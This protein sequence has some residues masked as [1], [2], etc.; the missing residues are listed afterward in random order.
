MRYALGMMFLRAL[1]A[2]ILLA[3]LQLA[4]ASAAG[5]GSD[6]ASGGDSDSRRR[7]LTQSENYVPLPPLTASVQANYQLRGILHIEAGLDIPDARQRRAAERAMPRLRDAYVSAISI[8][9]GV[10]YRHGDVPDINRI[11][12][13]LQSATDDALGHSDAQVLLGMVIIHAD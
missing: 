13:I 6:S 3:A 10:Q 2:A 1:F 12:E 11:A 7:T 8:Y 5:G 9:A 4:P